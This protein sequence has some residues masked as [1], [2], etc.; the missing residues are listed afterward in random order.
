MV[1]KTQA[2]FEQVLA[3]EIS[4]VHGTDIRMLRRAVAF[5]GNRELMYR[6]NLWLRCALR[7]LVPI[8]TAVARDADE[9]Y[10]A[11]YA[12]N[13]ADFMA[14]TD[15]F[16]IDCKT[17][18]E[19]HHHSLYAA[20]RI[21]DAIADQ[22]RDRKKSRPSVD[23]NF[24]TL[25]INV[26]I[27]DTDVTF[28][29]D[30]SGNSLHKRGYRLENNVAPLNEVTAAGLI[31]LTGWNGESDFGD[32]LCGS[33]TFLVEGAMVST[34]QAPGLKRSDGF[35]FQV[36]KDYD[37][38][39]WKSLLEE[40]KQQIC[41]PRGV[42]FGSDISN[43]TIDL[44]RRNIYRAGLTPFIRIGVSDFRKAKPPGKG[45]LLIMNPPY[46][47]R[48]QTDALEELYHDLGDTMKQSFKG[49]EAWILSGSPAAMKKFGLKA[50]LKIPILNGSIDCRFHKYEL[51]EGSRQKPVNSQGP[52][53]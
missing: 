45:G 30:S 4:A 46:G 38:V 48:M 23:L 13:W 19:I 10:R 44:A 36:W 31:A 43:E 5:R 25:R 47:E 6:A 7:V 17:N 29:I 15:T 52:E 32:L 37:K 1:A 3:D 33:G 9:L 50:S 18:S 53:D 12:F 21:K 35:G 34:R 27:N 11:T 14:H 24:P 39:L 40:A 2:G 8:H 26:L 41:K 49:F 42:I 16:A 22:F 28:S 51:Y 20:L